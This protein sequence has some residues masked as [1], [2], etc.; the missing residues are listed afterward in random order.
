MKNRMVKIKIK[1]I[2]L[3]WFLT[4]HCLL[5]VSPGTT[6]SLLRL[7]WDHP[8]DLH[9]NRT[10]LTGTF[11]GLWVA[12]PAVT[13][14]FNHRPNK[15]YSTLFYYTICGVSHQSCYSYPRT[16][17]YHAHTAVIYRNTLPV[18]Y[19]QPAWSMVSRSFLVFLSKTCIFL[20]FQ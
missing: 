3:T 9:L 20:W 12:S 8:R 16:A 17:G 18:P 7:H 14:T 2:R 19:L 10:M 1:L 15:L 5:Q 11:A 6:P 13:S 4:P